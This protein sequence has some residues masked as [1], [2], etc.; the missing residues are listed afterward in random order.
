MGTEL[1]DQ[2]IG[3]SKKID[4]PVLEYVKQVTTKWGFR[5]NKKG[6]RVWIN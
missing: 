5:R 3:N 4:V 2:E 1:L 6:V